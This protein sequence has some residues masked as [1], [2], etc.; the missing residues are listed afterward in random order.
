MGEND[1]TCI[2]V[3][4]QGK[5]LPHH[6][7]HYDGFRPKLC[8][9]VKGGKYNSLL[10]NCQHFA[11]LFMIQVMVPA[12]KE[13]ASWLVIAGEMITLYASGGADNMVLHAPL[14]KE[15]RTGII[16]VSKILYVYVHK[17]DGSTSRRMNFA[18]AYFVAR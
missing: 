7:F 11:E 18:I 2:S 15:Y 12:V 8:T 3:Y 10:N 14:L 4:E 9:P 5:Q 16:S 13:L 1:P 6:N 17:N